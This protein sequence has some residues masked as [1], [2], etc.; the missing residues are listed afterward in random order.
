MLDPNKYTLKKYIHFDKRKEIKYVESYVCDSQK[1]MRHSFLPL[2][3]FKSVSYKYTND[4]EKKIDGR[5]I[6]DK[7]RDIM[8]A[9]HLDGFIYRYYAEKLNCYYN[10]WAIKYG[11]DECSLAY[12]DNKK[13]QSNVEFAAQMI[14]KI[15]DFSDAYILIGDFTKYFDKL[16]HKILKNNLMRV[17]GTNFLESDWYNV[18]RSVTKYG[19][20]KKEFLEEKFG[21]DKKL[22]SEKRFS[23]FNSV[24]EFR[25]FQ[26][27]FNTEKNLNKY[28]IPQGVAISAVL[29]NIYAIEFD[30]EVQAI[31]KKL[32]GVY[33]RY[34]DDFIV[35]IPKTKETDITVL[36]E[37][38]QKIRSLAEEN[39]ITLQETKTKLFEL[40]NKVMYS[41]S[42]GIPAHLD[43]LGFLYD[44]ETVQMRAKSP[45]KFYRN[46][47]KLISKANDVKKGKKLNKIPYRRQLYR[48]YT[49][50]GLDRKN[51]SFIYYAKR[52]QSSFDLISPNTKN[53][54]MQQ[55]KNRKRKLEKELGYR[56]STKV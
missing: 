29:A 28:G 45:H 8:F 5:P 48:L 56:L 10:K 3:H 12:R 35:A 27:N 24:I 44:G 49:D 42:G 15:Y 7:P 26:R 36:K 40:N 37:I 41:V 19:Y 2:I 1:I 21:S 4:S 25:A 43:Y 50:Y 51:G 34:S 38:E 6:T 33:N 46:A 54:M 53:V 52:A 30:R 23:Y 17:M 13:G 16:D 47:Y 22:R 14:K 11:I 18:F 39:E 20:Y 32:G 9:G 55:I 31:A